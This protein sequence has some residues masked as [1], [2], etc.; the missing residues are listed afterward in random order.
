MTEF[1][2]PSLGAD[3][4]AGTLVA[5]RK[6]PGD[7]I[8]R[9]D[10]IAEV[11]TQKGLIE[12]EIFESGILDQYLVSEG[13]SVP[14]GTAMAL[15]R[16][17]EAPSSPEEKEPLVPEQKEGIPE[18][19]PLHPI[20]EIEEDKREEPE[21]LPTVSQRIKASPLA[22]KIAAVNKIDLTSL[23]G[24]GEEGAILRRD[25]EKVLEE[26]EPA[27]TPPSP[28]AAPRSSESAASEVRK[29]V[30]SAMSRANQE[31][32]HYYLEKRIDLSN[33]MEWLR[34]TNKVR[35]VKDRLLPVALFLRAT[36]LA[37]D[38]HP[39][40]NAVWDQGVQVQNEINIGLVLSLRTGGVVVPAIQQA[41]TRSPDQIMQELNELIPRAR[42][43]K[44][45]SSELSTSTVT[46]TSLGE[47]GADKVY[48]IIYPPQ[49]ALIGFGCV[50]EEVIPIK[51]MLAIRPVV[52]ATLAGDHRASD[53]LTGSRFLGSLDQFL[54]TPENL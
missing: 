28:T 3:M 4:E 21:D 1:L 41:D 46:V 6:K 40:L 27:K 9:G 39:T 26:K 12:V 30:A 14:V 52:Y 5:W 2:M 53:G 48:G 25:V 29:A 15:I 17:A 47:A 35:S 31:I 44:L 42:A 11:D 49:V 23:K 19:E 43:L 13:E 54:Q 36:A 10:I 32:P 7:Q 38:L 24:T 8:K 50:V 51:G 33:A 22:R 37:L 45:R 20:L 18:K 16:S 34:E